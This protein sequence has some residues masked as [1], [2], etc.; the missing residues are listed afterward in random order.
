[1][2]DRKK[3]LTETAAVMLGD[4]TITMGLMEHQVDLI[5]RIVLS[6]AEKY[7]LDEDDKFAVDSLRNIL[8]F[9]SIDFNNLEHP[10]ESYKIPKVIE[11]KE[12]TRL[13]QEKYL[14]AQLREGLL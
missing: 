7:E 5:G 6:I 2:D 13:V 10:F 8:K 9:S 12:R 11:G 4:T 3:E 14:Q 1:M